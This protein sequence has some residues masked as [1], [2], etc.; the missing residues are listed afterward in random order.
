MHPTLAGIIVCLAFSAFFSAVETSFTSLTVFQVQ[1]LRK[2]GWRGAIVERLAKKP[3]AL[4]STILIGNNVV[5]VLASVL[6]TEWALKAWKSVPIS[7]V[8][9]VITFAILIFGE[10]T[11]KR[12]AIAHSER[13]AL[14]FSP[15][16]FAFTLLFKPAVVVVN[17]ISSVVTRLFGKSKRHEVSMDTVM[18]MLSVAEHTGIID[19]AKASMVKNIFRLGSTTVQ[20]TMTHRKDV[21]SLERRTT[22]EEASRLALNPRHSRIP[23]YDG[24]PEKVT[25]VVALNVIVNEL[26]S[27]RGDRHIGDIMA[28]PFYVLPSK[29]ISDIFDWF[30]EKRETFAV[31]MDEYGGLAGVITMRDLIEEI[32]GEIFDES[33]GDAR[34]RIRK[35]PDG[36]YSVAGDVPLAL[37]AEIS[38]GEAP[39]IP[40]VQ[41]VAGY[42]A[43][44]LD[45]IP[46][47]GD[48]ADTPLGSF[49]VLSVA[50]NRVVSTSYTLPPS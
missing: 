4:I 9:G 41:T 20:A 3:D 48:V 5:N 49:T 38:G 12:V 7:V 31:V 11:P 37:M 50:D 2:R 15:F 27:G 1:S 6:A 23:V 14:A 43:L 29:P 47:P 30:K 21:F 19:Y 35:K 32:V 42:V 39:S 44:V 33:T 34:E 40:Y 22:C 26:L 16:I 46:A 24:D 25:G 28:P 18:Q 8:T 13:I 36:S 10:V 17:A 45:R